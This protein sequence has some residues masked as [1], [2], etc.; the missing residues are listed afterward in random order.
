MEEEKL[1]DEELPSVDEPTVEFK[2]Y[3]DRIAFTVKN[4]EIN[5]IL[6]EI[7]GYDLQIN[8][9]MEY[10]NNVDD[11]EAMVSGIGD[12]FRDMIMN[13]LLSHKQNE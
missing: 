13:Q 2:Y 11:V 10:I 9:N 8:F 3:S 1:L 12:M 5:K 6:L 7:S 4:P